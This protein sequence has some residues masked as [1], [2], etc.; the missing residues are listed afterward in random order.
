[1]AFIGGV[2]HTNIDLIYAD[3]ARLPAIGQEV[4]AKKFEMHLG[5]GVPATLVN[6]ARLGLPSKLLTFLGDDFFSNFAKRSLAEFGAETVNLYQG[7][8]IP[9]V[10]TSVMVC[11]QD[12]SF[13][14]Y[15]DDGL[16]EEYP[17]E[18]VY[19]NLHGAKIVDMH[20]GF[21]DV[22][23]RLKEEGTI[24]VFDTGWEDDLSIEKYKEYLKL[25]DYYLPNQKEAL[26]ITEEQT[27]EKAAER[28]SEFFPNVVIKLDKEGCLLK[29]EKGIQIIPPMK[30]VEAVDAT[31]GGDAFMSGFLYGLYH[32]YPVEQCIRFGNVTGGTCVQG[33]GCLTKYVNETEL[34][35]Q[36]KLIG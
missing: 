26:K 8:R 6:T 18:E 34:L 32:D 23:R 11:D 12:R 28:L 20:V 4:F 16:A 5:G 15:R 10:L 13:V 2:G 21:L 22:Y 29:N 9:V 36:V 17:M 30:N 7:S 19:R 31:G 25:A 35:E 27:V 14:S 33:I 1:M 3:L 24:L